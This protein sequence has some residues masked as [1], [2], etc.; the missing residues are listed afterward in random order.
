M[1]FTYIGP[2]KW[3]SLFQSNPSVSDSPA[4]LNSDWFWLDLRVN[5]RIILASARSIDAE[6]LASFDQAIAGY[7]PSHYLGRVKITLNFKGRTRAGFLTVRL[8]VFF[9]TRLSKSFKT[10]VFVIDHHRLSSVMARAR[11]L[12]ISQRFGGSS[13]HLIP[14]GFG[15]PRNAL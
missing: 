9:E 4:A 11:R 15:F 1:A 3:L 2:A 13:A 7:V 14:Y 8:P 10:L 6:F 12:V 5:G